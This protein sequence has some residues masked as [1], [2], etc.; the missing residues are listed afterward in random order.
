MPKRRSSNLILGRKY[1][2]QKKSTP[3]AIPQIGWNTPIE[4]FDEDTS[5]SPLSDSEDNRVTG[6][7]KTVTYGKT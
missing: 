5:G 6:T 4:I 1:I 7:L 2:R 3:I